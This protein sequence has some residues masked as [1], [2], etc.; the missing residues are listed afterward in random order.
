MA[1]TLDGT[2]GINTSGTLVATG[3]LTTSSSLTTG[4]GAVYNGLQASTAVASTSGT[5]VDFTSIPSWVK[6]ITILFNGVST[7][8]SSDLLFQLGTGGTPETSGYVGT[9]AKY[10]SGSTT[11]VGPV[12]AAGFSITAGTGDASYGL[13]TLNNISGNIWICAANLNGTTSNMNVVTGSKTLAGVL[14]M[15]RITTVSGTP[16]FDAGSIN[17]FYE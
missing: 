10:N 12:N 9:S 13:M 11:N 8:G 1:I 2:T 7:T 4:T 5:T 15:V 14:N 17:I 6:R 16:T 3:S